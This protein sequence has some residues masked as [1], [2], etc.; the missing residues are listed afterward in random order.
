MCG[1]ITGII[2]CCIRG[3]YA[4]CVL[5]CGYVVWL[6]CVGGVVTYV[7]VAVLVYGACVYGA[8]VYCNVCGWADG[9]LVMAM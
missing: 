8:G 3:Y 2:N 9:L 1:T 7:R 4:M 6:W 5:Q